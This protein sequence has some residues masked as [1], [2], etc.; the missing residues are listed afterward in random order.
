MTNRTRKVLRRHYLACVP[1]RLRNARDGYWRLAPLI[2]ESKSMQWL[3]FLV[4]GLLWVLPA[5]LLVRW[6]Q[7]PD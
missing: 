2:I 3:Y 5:G 4:A 6:M 7:K 1:G